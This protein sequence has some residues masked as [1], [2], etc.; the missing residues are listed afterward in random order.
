MSFRL[1]FVSFFAVTS[2]ACTRTPSIDGSEIVYSVNQHKLTVK[3]FSDRL[4]RKLRILD[5][6]TVKEPSILKN[7]KESV[8]RDF[9][10]HALT[11]DF[12]VTQSIKVSNAELEEEVNKIRA[13]YPDDIAFRRSLAEQELSL[14]DWRDQVLQSVYDR[15][16]FEKIREKLSPPTESEIQQD[17]NENKDRF[18]KKERIYIRQVVTDKLNKAEDL[19]EL[20]KKKDFVDVAKKFSISPEAKNGGLIGWVEKGSLETFDRVFNVSV[21]GLS[22]IIESPYGFHII[23][24]ERKA[25]AGLASKDEVRNLIAKD[26]L[27]RK[28]QA[29][30][31]GWID[32]QLRTSRVLRNNAVIDAIY[33]ETRDK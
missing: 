15:R 24:V 25:G 23:K 3:E 26:L 2:F 14:S 11:L 13:N 22:Q 31:M 5:A 32:K 29:E 30:F 6:I 33:I 4:A 7:A 12:S 8:L 16:V 10:I 9:L 18:R 28:E 19:K 17:Y 21:G 27:G 1:L 20:L